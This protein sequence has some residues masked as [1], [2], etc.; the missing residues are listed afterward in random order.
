MEKERTSFPIT[1]ADLKLME[2]RAANDWLANYRTEY[3]RTNHLEAPTAKQVRIDAFQIT[4]GHEFQM[5][6]ARDLSLTLKKIR[7]VS[8]VNSFSVTVS[9][10]AKTS[11]FGP[12]AATSEF[13]QPQMSKGAQLTVSVS[14]GDEEFRRRSAYVLTQLLADDR[15]DKGINLAEG[16]R[17]PEYDKLLALIPKKRQTT[18]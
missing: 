14:G 15:I 3:S 6:Q 8:G 5:K 4:L 18:L 2:A 16:H 1:N 11:S 12:D 9:G 7:D 13:I 17:T 10:S